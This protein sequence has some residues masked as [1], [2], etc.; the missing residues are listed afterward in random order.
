MVGV[1]TK[2][3]VVGEYCVAIIA[4]SVGVTVSVMVRVDLGVIVAVFLEFIV[5]VTSS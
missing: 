3:E 2:T 1:T 4:F 5:G